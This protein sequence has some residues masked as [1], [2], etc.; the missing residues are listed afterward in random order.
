MSQTKWI[1]EHGAANHLDGARIW[2][3]QPYYGRPHAETA[4][5][6]D[7]VYVS[8]YKGLGG[9]AGAV[10][11]GSAAFVDEARDW[12]GRLGG[13]LFQLWPLAVAAEIG[14]DEIVPRMPAYWARAQELAAA[15][16]KI[17]GVDVVPHP[18]QSPLLHVHLD[19]PKELLDRARADH[20]DPATAPLLRVA[21]TDAPSSR[22]VRDQR[23]RGRHGRGRDRV[24]RSGRRDA[25]ARTRP[26]GLIN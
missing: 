22:P 11:A 3:S 14:L 17:D 26:D 10:L 21:R 19:A 6:F 1:T 16:V 13:Q 8:L 23:L 12:R 15:L 18:P 25:R 2:E 24:L 7:T 5:L 4:A 9:I 20:T